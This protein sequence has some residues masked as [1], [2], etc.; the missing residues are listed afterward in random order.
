MTSYCSHNDV[1]RAVID[2]NV[3]VEGEGQ[4]PPNDSYGFIHVQNPFFSDP[5]NLVQGA[6]QRVR[7]ER[8]RHLDQGGEDSARCGRIGGGNRNGIRSAG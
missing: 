8:L 1:M 6:L 5:G 7:C 3:L 4:N 2:T